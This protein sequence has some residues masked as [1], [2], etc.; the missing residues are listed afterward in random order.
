MASASLGGGD[1]RARVLQATNI[2]ELIGRTVALKQR[3]RSYVGLCP[4]H[5]EKTPSFHVDPGKQ[6]FHCFGCKKSGN[7]ID[8]IIERD[9]IEFKQAMHLLA[10]AAGIEITEYAGSKQKTGERQI[11]LDAHSAACQCFEKILAHP[12]NG[13]PAREY[14]AK[15]G[16]N[17]KAIQQFQIGLTLDQWDG[18]LTHPLMRKFT[19]AQLAL[20]GLVKPRQSGDGH[21]D[22]F[23]NRLMFPIR[24]ESG[25]IIAFGGRVMPG[26]QDPAKYLNSP[27]TP[28]FSKGRCVFGIDL[29]RQRIVETRTVAVVEGYTD[30]IMAHQYGASNVVSVL[31][32]AL[33]EQHVNILRRFVDR[34]VLLFDAD[35]AGDHAV[36]RSVELFLT[37]PIEIAIASMPPGMDPDE[38]LL[39]NGLEGFN[40]LLANATDALEYKWKQLQRN[41]ASRTDL[42]GQQ[43][44]IEAY[45]KTLADARGSGPVDPI[46]WGGA[47]ARV[48]RLTA[49]PVEQLQQRFKLK[50]PGPRNLVRQN[51]P[52][53]AE[54][55]PDQAQASDGSQ[56]KNTIPVSVARRN[57]EGTI[58]GLLLAEPERFWDAV[59]K[60]MHP[61][62][63]RDPMLSVIAVRYWQHQEDEGPPV[64]SE[65]LSLLE[66]AEQ[67]SAALQWVEEVNQ[68]TDAAALLEGALAHLLQ[69]R[70]RG[71]ERRLIAEAHESNMDDPREMLRQLQKSVSKPD[72]RRSSTGIG[73]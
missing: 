38:Y 57:A 2:L 43:H 62:E 60:R 50:R 32:T 53:P 63:F 16:F 54:I 55:A 48:A 46:R 20:A 45:L 15:R 21:Y 56:P 11:L 61:E 7:A 70:R 47:L 51:V 26:S 67:K 14:L 4:F 34:I 31:G 39:A 3:G 13:L 69:E 65:F 37:Q 17:E 22:T 59:Q 18:L 40:A 49:I 71:E 29:A 68:A 27:E 6:Y 52:A 66:A 5:S 9:R 72:I 35:N 33:T 23:R 1:L 25:R 28:L 42:T 10:E 73:M 41:M 30:V 58:L 36:D 24:D 12:Q 64:L 44:A 19:P 8:F